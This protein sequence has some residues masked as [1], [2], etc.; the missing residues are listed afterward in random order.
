[1][2]LPT[3]AQDPATA[4]FHARAA[5]ATSDIV[6]HGAEHRTGKLAAR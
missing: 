3:G 4:A 2:T 5:Q 1:M 6:Y